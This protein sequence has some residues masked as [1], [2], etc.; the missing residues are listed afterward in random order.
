MRVVINRPEHECPL[1]FELDPTTTVAELKSRINETVG[2]KCDVQQLSFENRALKGTQELR[3]VVNDC[4]TT[5][6]G[7]ENVQTLDSDNLTMDLQYDMNGSSC[8]DCCCMFCVCRPCECYFRH[9]CCNTGCDL[10]INQCQW[11][12]WRCYFCATDN[13][14]AE[15]E[16]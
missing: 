5:Q 9:C 10:E 16:I 7:M 3:F 6:P 1:E 13:Q 2:V 14:K 4:V 11:F 8:V 12:C 15:A